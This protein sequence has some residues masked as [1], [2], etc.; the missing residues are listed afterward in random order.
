MTKNPAQTD[1]AQLLDEMVRMTAPTDEITAE[2]L[3]LGAAEPHSL[4]AAAQLRSSIQRRLRMRETADDRH[5][6]EP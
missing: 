2:I 1:L 5:L 3:A 4:P 6:W